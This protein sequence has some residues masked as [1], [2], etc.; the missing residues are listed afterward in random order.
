MI[1]QKTIE[2]LIKKHSLLEKD[3]IRLGAIKSDDVKF[4]KSELKIVDEENFINSIIKI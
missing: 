2:D 3:F 4:I 1:P